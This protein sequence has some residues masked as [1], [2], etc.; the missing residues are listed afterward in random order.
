MSETFIIANAGHVRR[1]IAWFGRISFDNR[2]WKVTVQR[3]EPGAG[4]DQEAV[5]RGMERQIAEFT[6]NDPDT[7][8]ETLL[9]KH[10][11]TEKIELAGAVLTRPARRTR[12]GEHKLSRSEMRDHMRF[13]E[14]FAAAELGLDVGGR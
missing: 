9:A 1:L 7:V 4:T 8:H 13:V 11:G 14:A 6:G 3:I 10:Y 5:L 2:P 12:T